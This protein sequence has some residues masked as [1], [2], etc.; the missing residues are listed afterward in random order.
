MRSVA[1]KSKP[2]LLKELHLMTT[3]SMGAQLSKNDVEEMQELALLITKLY[4]VR[5]QHE[6]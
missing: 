5:Q 6:V 2:E 3:E 1:E 4:Q